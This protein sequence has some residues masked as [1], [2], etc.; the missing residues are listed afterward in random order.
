MR[1]ASTSR[2]KGSSRGSPS[3][4]R[5]L[6]S[7]LYLGTHPSLKLHFAL[8]APGKHTCLIARTSPTFCAIPMR[9][10][11]RIHQP[12]HAH[13]VTG[14]IVAWLPVFTTAARC[15]ILVQALDYCRAHKG[16][17]IH[18]W[19]ILDNHFHA[20]LSGPD[21]AQVLADLK[22]HTARRLIE[23]LEREGCA[24]LL[25]QLQHFR[26]RH[27][28]ESRHQ[29]WQEGSHPQ[30]MMSDAIM[31]QKLE[32]L[33]NNPVKRGLVASPEHWRYSSAHEWLPGTLPLLRV[34]RWR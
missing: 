26:L 9:S 25:H 6:V 10:R 7:K 1:G 20:I 16:L 17:K 2:P 24:W 11:Y 5:S 19:V 27:K 23:Q 8:R 21:L 18:A 22:R 13:F 14:T 31:E 3:L 28:I 30:A 33:H 29:V 34:D 12:D 4:P 32:Y 15:D